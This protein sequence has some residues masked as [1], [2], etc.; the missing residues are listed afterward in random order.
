MTKA[1]ARERAKANAAKKGQKRDA[2][3]DQPG[4]VPPGRFDPG[5]GSIKAVSI[6]ANA[7]H[8]TK[9]QRGAGRSR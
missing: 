4:Q 5:S 7:R 9:G 3:A 6:K 2:N 1:K 8:V